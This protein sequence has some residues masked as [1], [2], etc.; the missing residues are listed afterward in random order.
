[1]NVGKFSPLSSVYLNREFPYI[2]VYCFF[3]RYL[4]I[5]DLLF[6]ENVDHKNLAIHR[7]KSRGPI[8]IRV[9]RGLC[10]N[11]LLQRASSEQLGARGDHIFFEK[12]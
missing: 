1:M 6:T 8:G 9:G 5:G 10:P 2:F 12:S 3:C 11:L 4:A 7:P